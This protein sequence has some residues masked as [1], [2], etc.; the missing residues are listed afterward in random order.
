MR[1]WFCDKKQPKLQESHY[2]IK[3][4]PI[5]YTNAPKFKFLNSRS[6]DDAMQY[7]EAE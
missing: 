6:K 1:E 3:G 7:D 2:D 5:K 4:L